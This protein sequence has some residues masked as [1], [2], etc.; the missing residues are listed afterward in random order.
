[1]PKITDFHCSPKSG[2]Y[3]P[4]YSIKGVDWQF[5]KCYE[6]EEIEEMKT[7]MELS[8]NIK[9]RKFP[10]TRFEKPDKVNIVSNVSKENMHMICCESLESARKLRKEIIESLEL[11]N[12][13]IDQVE[14][15]GYIRFV[16]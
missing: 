10:F 12:F 13:Y 4:Y 6:Y 5:A 14:E 9:D 7:Q 3:L 16:R 2:I 15:I 8:N 1:M 11:L